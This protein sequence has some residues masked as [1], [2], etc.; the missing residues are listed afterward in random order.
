MDPAGCLEGPVLF[1]PTSRDDGVDIEPAL[2]PS[3]VVGT[4]RVMISNPTGC[5]YRLEQ[6]QDLGR[7]EAPPPMCGRYA[8]VEVLQRRGK[9]NKP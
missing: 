1:D 5:S 9:C 3:P 7:E 6:G 2:L 8:R 4:A